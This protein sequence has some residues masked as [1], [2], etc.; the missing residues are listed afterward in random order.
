M[1][2]TVGDPVSGVKW[3]RRTTEKIADE[4][5][6]AGIEDSP[7]TVAKLLKGLGYRLRVNAKK[8]NHQKDPGRDAQF[9]YVS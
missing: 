3:T 6:S 5:R 2:D 8:L 4:L 1:H 9:A 7:N